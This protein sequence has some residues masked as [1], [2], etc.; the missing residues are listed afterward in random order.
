VRGGARVCSRT[1]ARIRG[2]V[3]DRARAQCRIG[4]W[5]ILVQVGYIVDSVSFLFEYSGGSAY[6][7]SYLHRA[8]EQVSVVDL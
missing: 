7:T 4:E 2:V 1:P 5:R 6:N 8:F 3:R